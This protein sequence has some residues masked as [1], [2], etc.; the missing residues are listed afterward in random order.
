MKYD[1]LS[2]IQKIWN[3]QVGYILYLC[4]MYINRYMNIKEKKIKEL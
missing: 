4:Y 2:S 1:I 3:E